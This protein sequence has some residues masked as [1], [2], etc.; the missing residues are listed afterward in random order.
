MN[1]KNTW[2]AQFRGNRLVNKSFLNKEPDWQWVKVGPDYF[3][4]CAILSAIS[5]LLLFFILFC[6]SISSGT[7]QNQVGVI[8]SGGPLDQKRPIGFIDP[9]KR[10][11]VV[12]IFNKTHRY[13]ANQVNRWVSFNSAN[14]D[15]THP[16]Y[17]NTK[18]GFR[19]GLKGRIY[20]RFIG[21]KN[22]KLTERF[23][24]EYGAR[25]FD[26]KNPYDGDEGFAHF[27]DAMV[28]PVVQN[29]LRQEINKVNC[30]ELDRSCALIAEQVDVSS[31]QISEI[32]QR[33]NDQLSSEIKSRLGAEYLVDFRVNIIEIELSSDVQSQV[34]RVS[35][36]R[37]R[38]KQKRLDV[39]AA[40]QDA[41]AI[42]I[43][44]RALASSPQLVCVE[45]AK[46][47]KDAGSNF[48]V[49]LDGSCKHNIAAVAASK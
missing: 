1:D 17:I 32:E 23:D 2:W 29:S 27:L 44:G 37:S 12:G 24:Q 35:I 26:G 11:R 18:D 28:I 47:L 48:T 19:V 39:E 45:A 16:Y 41:L 5:V 13:P 14:T 31:T 20:F 25:K 22:K 40:K 15:D 10:Y 30:A 36:A 43:R 8:V 42:K 21:Q 46:E 6:L 4:I 3:K 9:G 38:I 7:K 33:L 49:I 34:N